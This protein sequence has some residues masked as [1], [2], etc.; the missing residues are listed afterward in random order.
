MF[1]TMIAS[2]YV[3]WVQVVTT[4]QE[5][6]WIPHTQIIRVKQKK[7]TGATL[8][9]KGDDPV[10]TTHDGQEIIDMICQKKEN[11]S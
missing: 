9:L 1:E 11:S 7:G 3:I 6:V 8:I 5:T 2:S 10:F 4:E